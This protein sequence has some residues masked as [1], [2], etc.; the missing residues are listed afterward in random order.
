MR[1]GGPPPRIGHMTQAQTAAVLET[2]AKLA[3]RHM[4]AGPM[5]SKQAANRLFS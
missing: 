1:R 2:S 4:Q 5:A 3:E